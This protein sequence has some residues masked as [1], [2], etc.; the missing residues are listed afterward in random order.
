MTTIQ[1]VLD[2]LRTGLPSSVYTETE[3]A[4]HKI[5]EAC[6]MLQEIIDASGW[7]SAESNLPEEMQS[8]EIY[9][10]GHSAS[11]KDVLVGYYHFGAFY[12]IGMPFPPKVKLWRP[13]PLPPTEKEIDT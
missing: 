13:I 8:I 4:Q 5:Y 3:W 11:A 2:L 7:R 6:G 9:A 10:P 1:D 12:A